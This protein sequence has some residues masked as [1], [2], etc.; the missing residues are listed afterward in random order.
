[1]ALNFQG[2][3][4]GPVVYSLNYSN[5]QIGIE[6]ANENA[7]QT[8]ANAKGRAANQQI[9][10]DSNAGMSGS[11]QSLHK[12]DNAVGLETDTYNPNIVP[13]RFGSV[14]STAGIQ[15]AGAAQVSAQGNGVNTSGQIS[16]SKITATPA[17][18]VSSPQTPFNFSS[19]GNLAAQSTSRAQQL[20]KQI[21]NRFKRGSTQAQLKTS[22]APQ[23][24][25]FNSHKLNQAGFV[26]PEID[27]TNYLIT[28]S[29]ESNQGIQFNN[30]GNSAVQLQSNRPG[31]L[32]TRN[33]LALGT[34]AGTN[35]TSFSFIAIA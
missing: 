6:S 16:N 10:S 29:A 14:F 23:T 20:L 21:Q 28:S 27:P 34:Q 7:N 8:Q 30:A 4:V 31:N 32:Q 17:I 5:N 19:V 35:N 1:M 11:L 13:T 12:S 3:L 33:N 22:L 9:Q 15:T 24:Q 26:D 18:D 2:D 25:V